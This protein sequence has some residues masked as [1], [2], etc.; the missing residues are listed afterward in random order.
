MLTPYRKIS[1]WLT[2][3]ARWKLRQ[4]LNR[5]KEDADRLQERH[6]NPSRPRPD[7]P[8]AW[9][10]AASVGEALSTLPLIDRIL[11]EHETLQV[12]LTTGTV[13]S[14]RLMAERLPARAFHQYAPVDCAPWV[15]RFLD[16]WRPEVALWVESELWPNLVTL[17]AARGVPMTLVNARMS[18]ASFKRWRRMPWLARP[19]IS[20]FGTVLAQTSSSAERFRRLGAQQVEVTGNIKNAAEPLPV[21]DMELVAMRSAIGGRTLWVAAS[22]HPG[23]ETTVV[24]AHRIIRRKTPDLL[25]VIVPRH[26]ERGAE[27]AARLSEDDI[28]FARRGRQ[29]VPAPETGIYLADTLGELGLFYRLG[30]VVF[31]G[32][33]LIRHGGQNPLEPALLD[34][35]LLHGPNVENFEDIFRAMDEAGGAIEVRD[36]ESLAA[37]ALSFLTDLEAR[38]EA[39]AA[40]RKVATAERHVLDRAMALLGPFVAAALTEDARAPAEPPAGSPPE[41]PET[42]ETPESPSATSSEPEPEASSETRSGPRAPGTPQEADGAGA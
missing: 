11:A 40:A 33:S 34:S 32:G 37:G 8:L 29:Q 25:T 38:R 30:A 14:A 42:P 23:E 22:T 2:P 13:T 20:A 19:M 7:G 35:A 16:H 4:R 28:S 18:A 12:M 31:V 6:G 26:P 24:A 10:H 21:D 3:V 41:S 36:A 17:T 39:I 5:G 1:G 27:L 9:I 15:E